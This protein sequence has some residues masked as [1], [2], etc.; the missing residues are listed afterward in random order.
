MEKD[1]GVGG[2][3]NPPPSCSGHQ[4]ALLP[5]VYMGLHMHIHIHI[6]VYA[7]SNLYIYI[8]IDAP[9][10]LDSYKICKRIYTCICIHRYIYMCMHTYIGAHLHLDLYIYIEMHIYLYIYAYIYSSM[11]ISRERYTYLRICPISIGCHGC[12]TAFSRSP[13]CPP[14]LYHGPQTISTQ[15]LHAPQEKLFVSMHM[16]TYTCVFAKYIQIYVKTKSTILLY[17]FKT[18]NREPK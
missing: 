6:Y 13:D 11:C 15:N 8:C 18:K 2:S 7:R 9:I 3:E 12:R 10:Y 5:Y 16:Y 4:D 17:F 14:A 1:R